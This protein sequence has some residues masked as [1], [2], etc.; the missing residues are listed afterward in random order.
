MTNAKEVA[1]KKIEE[2]SNQNDEI[3]KNTYISFDGWDQFCRGEEDLRKSQA[4]ERSQNL[5]SGT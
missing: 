5:E 1:A 4:K 2:E 3:N